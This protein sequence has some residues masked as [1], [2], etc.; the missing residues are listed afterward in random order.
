MSRS[1]EAVFW[2]MQAKPDERRTQAKAAEKF[3]IKQGSVSLAMKRYV[4]EGIR[5]DGRKRK[6]GKTCPD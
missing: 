2:I 6:G 5:P 3:G 1:K 4:A